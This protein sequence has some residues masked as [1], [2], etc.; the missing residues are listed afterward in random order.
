M[1]A[2]HV[3]QACFSHAYCIPLEERLGVEG[4]EDAKHLAR[5]AKRHQLRYRESPRAL[6]KCHAE[7][8][9]WREGEGGVESREGFQDSLATTAVSVSIVY[10][11]RGCIEYFISIAVQHACVPMSRPREETSVLPSCL[12]PIPRR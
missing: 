11:C 2:C 10:T 9:S 6:S 1:H 12:S 5:E 8:N 3:L 7:V 4:R